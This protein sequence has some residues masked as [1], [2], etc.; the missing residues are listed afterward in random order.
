MW[1]C[2]GWG[3]L[4]LMATV[5][6]GCGSSTS[7]QPVAAPTT[8]PSE[9]TETSA[10]PARPR[11]LRLDGKDPCALIPESD[12]QKLYIDKPGEREQSKAFKSPACFYST[13]RG[14]MTLTLVM[15]EGIEEW[16]GGKRFA[17]P[18]EV[19]PVANFPAIELRQPGN[20][21]GCSVAVDVADG[22]YLLAVVIPDSDSE[23]PEKCKFT[24]RLAETAMS[25]LVG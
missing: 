9:T 22:Q 17:K 18:Y 24:Y 1:R 10:P 7:G 23:L 8:A 16:T 14:T 20:D 2:G 13:H 11:E 4:T 15:T 3:M 5:L 19:E 25:T 21:V 12:W 6:A